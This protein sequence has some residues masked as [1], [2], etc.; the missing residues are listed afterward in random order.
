MEYTE[1]VSRLNE[2][3]DE[4]KWLYCELY[5]NDMMAFHYFVDMLRRAYADRKRNCRP[6]VV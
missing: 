3:Y 1:F 2:R 4:L 5:H 6:R